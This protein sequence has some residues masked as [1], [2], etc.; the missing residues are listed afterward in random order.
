MSRQSFEAFV[1]AEVLSASHSL[2][3][4]VQRLLCGH[5][6]E[7][8]NRIRRV[9]VRLAQSKVGEAQFANWRNQPVY[10]KYMALPV[11]CTLSNAELRERRAGILDAVRRAVLDIT[12]LP[13]GYAYSFDATSEILPQLARLVDLERHAARS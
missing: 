12:P 7:L 2:R 6:F 13:D 8:A 1:P 9:L 5:I 10:A 3:R 4:R 11:A